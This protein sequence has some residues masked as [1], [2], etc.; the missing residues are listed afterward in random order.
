[1]TVFAI[2]SFVCCLAFK[3]KGHVSLPS[4]KAM[5]VH[6]SFALAPDFLSQ[7]TNSS[8]RAT[9]LRVVSITKNVVSHQTTRTS[10]TAPLA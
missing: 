6:F 2:L 3:K 8:F 4:V 7:V 1:M 5:S 10:S 9:M